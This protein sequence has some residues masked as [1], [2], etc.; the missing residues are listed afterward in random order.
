MAQPLATRQIINAEEA[1]LKQNRL[2]LMSQN[3][4]SHLQEM[5]DK[6][7]LRISGIVTKAVA[8]ALISTIVIVILVFIRVLILPLAMILE[9]AIVGGMVYMIIDFNSFVHNLVFDEEAR[10]V[11]IV[12]GRTSRYA[13]RTHPLY[14]SL[15][16]ETKNYRL[17]DASL[18]EQ[19]GTGEL[20][21]L[22][23]LPQSR[24]VIAAEKVGEKG[25]GYLR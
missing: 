3:Q 8:T 18:L 11:R 2:G 25:T 19:F 17:L 13:M 15:R 22:Y 9:L 20:Y 16:V 7:Q 12:K 21:Q 23:V 24:V 14:S 1:D 6:Y 10:A 5:V 4:I